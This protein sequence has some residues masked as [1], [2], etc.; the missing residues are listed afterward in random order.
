MGW[1]CAC[2]SFCGT[3]HVTG[4]R[5]AGAASQTVTLSSRLWNK[6]LRSSIP[7]STCMLTIS[8]GTRPGQRSPWQDMLRNA[9][10]CDTFYPPQIFG[11]KRLLCV[12]TVHVPVVE[13]EE[14]MEMSARIEA[15]C[16]AAVAIGSLISMGWVWVCLPFRLEQYTVHVTGAL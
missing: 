5:F 1:V 16:G 10:H 4:T 14:I 9:H 3:V 2:L 8:G 7:T 13:T 6:V 12:G 11:A 15:P